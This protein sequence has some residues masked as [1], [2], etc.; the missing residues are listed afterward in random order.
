MN[1][2]IRKGTITF[3]FL[4]D[5]TVNNPED[6]VQNFTVE[7]ILYHCS[8]EHMVGACALDGYD[9]QDVAPEDVEKELIAL[10]N[11]GT[12]FDT[13]EDEEGEDD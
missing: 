1:K 12:F 5:T 2:N 8:N 13:D 9:I 3:T 7:D 4:F 6:I 11:D 10:D